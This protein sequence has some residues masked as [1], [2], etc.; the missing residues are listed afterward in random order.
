VSG[1]TTELALKTAVDSDDNADYL[2]ISL[3]SSLQTLDALFSNTTGHTH[4]G[5]HQGGPIGTASIPDGSITSA[6][7][8]DG[9]LQTADLAANA[10][11]QYANQVGAP[12]ASTNSSTMVTAPE[13]FGI[14]GAT[15]TVKTG[16]QVVLAWALVHLQC[17]TATPSAPIGMDIGFG[18]DGVSGGASGKVWAVYGSGLAFTG[19]FF[20]A[21]TG[22]S[23]GSHKVT[24]YWSSPGSVTI[25]WNAAYYSNL[26]VL[27]LHR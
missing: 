25:T 21:W 26:G 7:I 14:T 15:V 5:A 23:V 27:V 12:S 16:S 2:T 1:S 19:L 4:S 10:V 8:L 13:P 22:L 20:A 18:M 3:A 11:S 9:T 24:L 6:K 17:A